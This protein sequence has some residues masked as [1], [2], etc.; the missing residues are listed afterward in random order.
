[1]SV[2]IIDQ[3]VSAGSTLLVT[4]FAARELDPNA[5]G[6]F[7]MVFLVYVLSI[8]IIRAVV[9]L[10]ALVHPAA[11]D[12]PSRPFG[13]ALVL[14]GWIA[15]LCTIV[16]LFLGE[17]LGTAMIALAVTLPGLA[18]L[19]V[20]R[21][22]AFAN[23]RPIQ[24]LQFDLVWTG[25][26]VLGLA[27][28]YTFSAVT[29]VRLTLVWGITGSVGTLLVLWSYRGH[30]IDVSLTWVRQT[31]SFSWR[32]LVSFGTSAGITH[33]ITL[34]LGAIAGAAAVGSF[35]G[36]QFIVSPINVLFLGAINV[37]V[38]EGARSTTGVAEMTRRMAKVSFGMAASAAVV[39]AGT[40]MLSD[41]A[42]QLLLGESWDSAKNLL[43]P[44]G[45]GTVMLGIG[46]GAKIGL[47]GARAVRECL[48]LDLRLA[49]ILLVISLAGTLSYS[50]SGLL[51]AL[52]ASNAVAAVMWW[53][54]FL[55]VLAI[56]ERAATAGS[57]G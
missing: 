44:A 41:T 55:N 24:A 28:L 46:G 42:G 33:T 47:I 12:V 17:S 6:V 43:L 53:R 21:Y 4:V 56:R 40:L 51:W 1:V 19:D 31:W 34:A 39:T 36:A 48:A 54:R 13:A 3:A 49:P 29:V 50:A 8:G 25:V 32:Y 7:G 14:S 30:E 35:R 15:A 16:G 11:E 27:T 2:A 26:L 22:L 9:S 18:L 37:L 10:P 45:L 52:V 57:C 38:S 20:G 23:Q 5:F